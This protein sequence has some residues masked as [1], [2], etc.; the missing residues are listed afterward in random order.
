M[1]LS[2]FITLHAVKGQ[3]NAL[4]AFLNQGA[5][6]VEATEPETLLWT[7]LQS[8]D[9]ST[10]VIFDTFADKAGQEAHF[11]GRVA[12]ALN[13]N[14]S[15]LVEGGW[16]NGVLPNVLNGAIVGSKVTAATDD[17]KLAVW[18][19]L[20]A[21]EGKRQALADLLAI[22]GQVVTETEPK[23]LYWFGLQ[24]DEQRFGILDFFADAS[25]IEAHFAGDA[26]A[27]VKA[28]AAA[29]I[30]GGWDDGVV[31]NLQ[32]FNVLAFMGR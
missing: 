10:C 12:A 20:T 27:A 24:I 7:A 14:A 29:L 28:N 15:T 31:A 18:I 30:E 3:E 8:A 22:G 23:T 21:K 6:I 16:D 5:G 26:A 1:K 32:Q 2:N 25:G 9:S 19:P 11:A 13:A 17:V 4:A